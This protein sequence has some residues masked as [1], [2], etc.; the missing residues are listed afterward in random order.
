[1]SVNHY[2][3]Y[4]VVLPW[5]NPYGCFRR[6]TCP[7]L[8]QGTTSTWA[9]QSHDFNENSNDSPP[10]MSNPPSNP[11]SCWN[12]AFDTMNTPP[13]MAGLKNGNDSS[14]FRCSSSSSAT[15]SQRNRRLQS[16][17]P[18]NRAEF[19]RYSNES[20]SI[21]SMIGL[22]TAVE[23]TVNRSTNGSNQPRFTSQ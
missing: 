9:P 7:I 1:M 6:N 5:G 4:V 10:H 3:K 21:M 14:L 16:N 17:P 2:L 19:G 22:S 20:A 23:S 11:P 8:E 15:G 18:R 12:K 13:D